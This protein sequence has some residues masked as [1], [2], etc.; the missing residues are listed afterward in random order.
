[1][2]PPGVAA[3][4]A[5]V[6]RA[7]GEHLTREAREIRLP[8]AFSLGEQLSQVADRVPQQGADHG[9]LEHAGWPVGPSFE[10][11]RPAG[12]PRPGAAIAPSRVAVAPPPRAPPPPLL[13]AWRPSSASRA[14]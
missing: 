4:A 13:V 1:M 3:G 6:A 11:H 2:A 10:G 12:A 9:L 8:A 14:I 7:P 5:A